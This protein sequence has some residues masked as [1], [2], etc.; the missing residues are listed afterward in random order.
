MTTL[1]LIL[2]VCLLPPII[3]ALIDVWFLL[4]ERDDRDGIVS[5]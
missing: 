5:Y 2:I 3:V 1:N 4:R